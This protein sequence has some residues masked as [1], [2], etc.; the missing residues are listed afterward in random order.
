MKRSRKS[1][2]GTSS[3]PVAEVCSDYD[4]SLV[5]LVDTPEDALD[6]DTETV[7]PSFDLD[8]SVRSDTDYARFGEFL[9]RLGLPAG[10][11]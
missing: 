2:E 9:R 1:E 3:G 5:H 8:T 4:A 10:Q 11:R 6:T 7:D